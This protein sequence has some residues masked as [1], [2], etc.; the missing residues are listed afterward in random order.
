MKCLRGAPVV[1]IAAWL[2]VA[3]LLHA[4]GQDSVQNSIPGD[5]QHGAA[6]ADSIAELVKQLDSDRFQERQLAEQQLMRLGKQAIPEIELALETAEGEA[7]ARLRR[8]VGDLRRSIRLVEIHQH[9]SLDC[10]T[11]ATVSNDGRFLYTA[12]WKACAVSQFSVDPRTGRLTFVEALQDAHDWRG[13]VALRLSADD[14]LA[15]VTSFSS[16]TVT[17]LL[18]N[19][20]TGKLERKHTVKPFP[21]EPSLAF[22]IDASFSP[23]SK[24]LYVLDTNFRGANTVGAIFVYRVSDQNRLEFVETNV[25]QKTCFQN[26]R[27]IAFHPLLDK[28]YVAAGDPGQLVCVEFDRQTGQTAVQQ[29]IADEKDGVHG[30]SGAM[31][32]AVSADG[33]FLYSSSGRFRGDSAVSVFKISEDGRLSVIEE[34]ISGRDPTG[35][36]L[37][38]NELLVS[39][40]GKNVYATGTRSATLAGFS[41][42]VK[43]GMLKFIETVSLGGNEL[44][45][46]GLAIGADGDYLYVAVEG[47]GGIAVF[48]RD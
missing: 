34:H 18:R 12:A 46:A 11:S 26:A 4:V 19:K 20:D 24:H 30:L 8:I 43:T 31:S 33:R 10:V 7:K 13:A 42:D 39:P 1:A 14:Q 36:F 16:K 25:G 29:I 15:A 37:G 6:R 32:V 45:P 47:S 9:P 41:R 27:G 44:G 17:L 40:D 2:S 5:V 35:N 23:D 22:P 28:F 3:T 38:G 21:T 48:R